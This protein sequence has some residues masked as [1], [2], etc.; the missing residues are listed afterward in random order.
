MDT[1]PFEKSL[2]IRRKIMRIS[3]LFQFFF[4]LASML[5]CILEI[6]FPSSTA[7]SSVK[8]ISLNIF[9]KLDKEEEKF[10][11]LSINIFYVVLSFFA[12]PGYKYQKTFIVILHVISTS[13]LSICTMSYF[14]YMIFSKDSKAFIIYLLSPIVGILVGIFGLSFLQFIF[15]GP[16]EDIEIPGKESLLS[17]ICTNC[18]GR[19]LTIKEFRCGHARLCDE[20]ALKIKFCDLCGE[21]LD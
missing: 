12:Y 11:I 15:N 1:D 6:A 9:G 21:S 13:I 8:T 14:M 4:S 5:M 10:C 7:N 2:D 17:G 3:V 18:E 19:A 16:N 20:C